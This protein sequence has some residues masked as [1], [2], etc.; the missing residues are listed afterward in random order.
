MRGFKPR[1][2]SV[3]FVREAVW[4]LIFRTTMI[5]ALASF[6]HDVLGPEAGVATPLGLAIAVVGLCEVLHWLWVRLRRP[7]SSLPA[8]GSAVSRTSAPPSV[9]TAAVPT[10][11]LQDRRA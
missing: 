10:D 4:A 6:C 2:P 7:H 5:M 3:A 9:P 1:R 8:T 11:L